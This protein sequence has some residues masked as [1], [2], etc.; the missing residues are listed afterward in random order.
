MSPTI[1]LF[2]V[3]AYTAL[4]FDDDMYTKRFDKVET[5]FINNSNKYGD[6]HG[7]VKE[8]L[9]IFKIYKNTNK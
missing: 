4:L 5:E 1:I 2:I 8:M 9:Q 6:E 7:I 3:L